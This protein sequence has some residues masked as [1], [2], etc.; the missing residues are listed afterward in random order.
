MEVEKLMATDSETIRVQDN[1]INLDAVQGSS[2]T[3]TSTAELTKWQLAILN[4]YMTGWS[5]LWTCLY[6]VTL[7]KQVLG[8][9]CA[10][11]PGQYNYTDNTTP[12]SSVMCEGYSKGAALSLVIAS[13]GPAQLLLP[14][15]LGY[16]SDNT[17]SRWGSRRPFI[18]TGM[19][20]TCVFVLLL[21][22]CETL[23]SLCLVWFLLQVSSNI[24]SNCFMALIAD[25]VPNSQFGSGS[26]VM[27]AFSCFGQFLGAL[28][29]ITQEP[30]GFFGCYLLLTLLHFFTTL[31]TLLFVQDSEARSTPPE[32]LGRRCTFLGF[33]DLGSNA[34]CQGLSAV[35]QP[36]R[37]S[38]DFTWV[39]ITRLLFNMG[40]YTVQEFL[41]YYLK[42]LIDTGNI[43]SSTAVSYLLLP[44]LLSAAVTA[45]FGGLLSDRLGGKRKIFVYISG[46]I[47]AICNVISMFNRSYE[48]MFL[49][50]ILFGG[51][52]G[53]FG[54][55]DF[56]LVC[57]VL[58]NKDNFAVSC[59]HCL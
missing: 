57:D 50:C 12:S 28:I 14:P 8:I 22:M 6:V 17:F 27:G 18:L 20:L 25:V 23:G 30:L 15:L 1:T 21:P 31:P 38:L 41:Q 19:L 33:K 2:T 48:L 42:D 56:A 24:G 32:A 54:S 36:F 51:A 26:G 46:A 35:M 44:M 55:V 34:I 4:S 40:Q 13:G 39:F 29:G 5:A 9:I 45:F 52:F 43:P 58:P 47:M 10:T 53:L 37:D 7:P 11:E 59:F 49:V 16:I 3:S